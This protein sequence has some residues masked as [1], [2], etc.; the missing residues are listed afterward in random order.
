[1]KLAIICANIGGIDHVHG[2]PRQ[3]MD[4]T[5][6][7]YTESNLPYPL[8]NLNA[9]MRSKYIKIM[10]H[11]FLPSYDAYIWIDGKV[12]VLTNNF[13][14]L[15]TNNLR[16]VNIFPHK[17]RKTPAEELMFI[18]QHMS[19]GN[20]YL[21]SRYGDQSIEKEKQ[22]LWSK[23]MKMTLYETTLFARV[24]SEKVN[25]LFDQWWL[26]TL[27]YSCF[28]QA[29]FSDISGWLNIGE[30][31]REEFKDVFEINKHK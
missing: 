26:R 4:Y 2:L 15:M 16:E 10:M 9:R 13:A 30:L 25:A 20:R 28:D 21:L 14:E 8:P 29:M 5:Y 17:D 6:H 18:E 1:M 7:Y 19:K 31:N 3:N 22:Y 12:K 23:G 27:E 11:R 24:N